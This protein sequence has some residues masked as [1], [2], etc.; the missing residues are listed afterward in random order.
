MSNKKS[1]F[2]GN[3]MEKKRISMGLELVDVVAKLWERGHQKASVQLLRNYE[4][5]KNVPGL[6]YA[7]SLSSIYKCGVNEFLK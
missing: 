2:S 6:E 7:V 5:D 3:R 4:S 1:V